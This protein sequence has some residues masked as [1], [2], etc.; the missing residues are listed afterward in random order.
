MPEWDW[1]TSC[2]KGHKPRFY[3]SK[4]IRWEF[5]K[6]DHWG[7]KRVCTDFKERR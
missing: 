6:P 3:K 5:D 7:H 2:G 4:G 1:R